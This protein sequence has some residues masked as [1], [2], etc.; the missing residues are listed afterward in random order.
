MVKLN[1]IMEFINSFAPVSL[2]EDYDN[3]GL[4]VGN[5]EKEVS[6]V[7]ITLDIDEYVAQEADDLGCE[8]VI[9]H[10]PLIFS[11]LKRVTDESS[12]SRTV[13]SLIKN[14]I[15]LVSAHTNFDS[16]N[17]GLC[18]LFLDK[19]AD[20]KKRT[21]LQ[22]DEENGCGRVAE[23]KSESKLSDI[24]NNVKREFNLSTVRYVGDVDKPIRKVAVCN[25]GGADFVYDACSLGADLYITGDIKY[26]HA[27]FAY[28]NGMSLV[29]VP[30]YNAE[31]IFCEYMKE[32]LKKQFGN[33]LDICVTDK[34]IDIW[35]QF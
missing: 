9:S 12:I 22:G 10:H 21:A 1:K 27:R 24:L 7:L 18:D 30:H 35:N 19:I 28:E 23:L 29:E 34:N 33:D 15:S 32:L 25:G 6:R 5:S 8:L 16:T 13:I 26:H 31:I 3:V 2:A 11:P 4:L 20:T 17:S 14:D